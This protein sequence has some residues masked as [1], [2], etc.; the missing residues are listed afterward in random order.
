MRS[1]SQPLDGELISAIVRG[2]SHHE[3]QVR[4]SGK[5][6]TSVIFQSLA[7][8][9][10]APA[11]IAVAPM[12]CKTLQDGI[13]TVRV[14]GIKIR[15]YSVKCFHQWFPLKSSAQVKKRL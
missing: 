7:R 14:P 4:K 2:R 13:R 8:Q 15:L 6:R 5:D 3:M 1:F 9:I 11:R 10:F 12:G